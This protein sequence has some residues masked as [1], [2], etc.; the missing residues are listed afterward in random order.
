[1][2]NTQNQEP[3]PTPEEIA[4]AETGLR[5]RGL[6]GETSSEMWMRHHD[7]RADVNGGGLPTEEMPSQQEA[8]HRAEWAVL[9]RRERAELG[10]AWQAPEF[11][12]ATI[13]A[14]A[15]T[16]VYLPIPKQADM[17]LL[18]EA[19]TWASD[20]V[21]Y[22]EEGRGAFAS[23]L[24]ALPNTAAEPLAAAEARVEELE[25]R[26]YLLN[27]IA[28]TASDH[29]ARG[30]ERVLDIAGNASDHLARSMER[31]LDTFFSFFVAEPKMTAQQA[32]E[33]LQAA[34]NVET[35]HAHDVAAGVRANE[36]AHDWQ[37]VMTIN[38]QQYQD[39]R[40]A[41]TLGTPATA[42]ANLGTDEHEAARQQQKLSL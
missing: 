26:I 12:R 14:D 40:L 25:Q 13:E 17:A 20:L 19:H 36:A 2:S 21:R 38:Q 41:Q 4:H 8:R 18:R 34:G 1:M 3:K 39:V 32:H 29:L 22:S 31:V 27:F 37:S 28:H 7:E 5:F 42:E 23:P 24:V 33:H 9:E 16:A 15:W 6:A 35:L 30:V 10:A 11:S